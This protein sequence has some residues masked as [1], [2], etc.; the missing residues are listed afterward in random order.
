LADELKEA[1]LDIA[2]VFTFHREISMMVGGLDDPSAAM[3]LGLN[4]RIY[5]FAEY[6]LTQTA[7]LKATDPRDKV[8]A[9][10]VFVTSYSLRL[11]SNSRLK[12]LTPDYTLDVDLVM[13]L[14]TAITM[15]EAHSIDLLSY[16]SDP[17]ERTKSTLPAWVPHFHIPGDVASLETLLRI[18][19]S[20]L[21]LLSNC[22]LPLPVVAKQW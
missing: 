7:V 10:F 11:G 2:H 8:F 6:C 16:V 17:S 15:Q 12:W 18:H 20:K 13:V 21:T 9:L 1:I 22:K 3:K 14:T 19:Q 5:K 4:E